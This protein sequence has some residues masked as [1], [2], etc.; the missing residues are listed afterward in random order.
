[1]KRSAD[2][3]SESESG[4]T[5]ALNKSTFYRIRTLRLSLYSHAYTIGL[6]HK[7]VRNNARNLDVDR[8]RNIDDN[9]SKGLLPLRTIFLLFLLSFVIARDEAQKHC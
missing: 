1:M 7:S 4:F 5:C 2:S 3:I 6:P 9:Q 8:A